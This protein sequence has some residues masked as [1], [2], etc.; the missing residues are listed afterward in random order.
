M[1]KRSHLQTRAIDSFMDH[2]GLT[3]QLLAVQG[4]ST[5]RWNPPSVR[6]AMTVPA[7]FRAVTL[8]ANVTGSLLMQAWRNGRLMETPP[9]LVSRPGVFSTPR[10]FFRDTAYS[11]ASYGEYIW[12]IVDRDEANMA[13]KFLLLPPGEVQVRWNE[14]FRLMRE[15]TW[16]NKKLDAADIEHGTFAREPGG[17]RGMGPLQMCG[18]A[19]S[20][21]VEANEWA[22]SEERRVGKECRSRWSP[23]H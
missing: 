21:A 2:P 18:A 16:R 4:L 7:V 3:E 8:I 1:L 6:E 20:V 19:L 10:D 23:Y 5:T 22:R 12:W 14:D 11:L 13:R 17:L 15:Y 9:P